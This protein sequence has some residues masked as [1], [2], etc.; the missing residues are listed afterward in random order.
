MKIMWHSVAPWVGTGYGMQ[1][2]L[3]TTRLAELGNDVR[4]SA[5]YG[6]QGSETMWRG[7]RVLPSYGAAYGV[8][9]IVPHAVK[10]FT[11]DR[12]DVN[13]LEVSGMGLVITLCDVWTQREAPL[14]DMLAIASWT[15]VDHLTVPTIVDGFF[16]QSGAI[17]IAMSRFGQEALANA[18]HRALYVP[19]GVDTRVFK[20]GDQDQARVATGTPADAFVVGMVANNIGRDGNRKAFAEQIT[21]FAELRRR[22][23]DAFLILHTDVDAPGGMRIRPF[24]ER[25]LPRDSY[26]FSDQYAYRKGL[27]AE[28]VASI[29]RSM[30]VLTNCSYGEG[31]GVPIIEAQACG[32]PVVVT[33]A[34]AMT[35]LSGPG[36]LVGYERMW[37]DSQGA[38][39]ATPRIGDIVDAYE[40]AYDKARDPLMR[41]EAWAFAQEYD[42]DRITA[43]HWAPALETLEAALE[44]RRTTVARRLAIPAHPRQ[45]EQVYRSA[46]GFM[47]I[48]RGNTTDDWVAHDDH[49]EWLDVIM[50]EQLPEGGVLLDVGAHV[51][52]W[53][54]RLSPKALHVVAVEA[55]PTTAR[56]LRRHLAMNDVHNVTVLEM[57]A[58]DEETDLRIEDPNG[59]LDGGGA[60]VYEADPDQPAEVLGRRLDHGL[61]MS[62]FAHY[63]RLDLV[64]MDVEGA[65]LHALRGMS[66]LLAEYRPAMIIECHDIYGYYERAD[67]EALLTELG[68]TF[69]VAASV[70][71]NWQPGVGIIDEVRSA[72]Y[73]LARP[74]QVAAGT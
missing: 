19:H 26:A 61:I 58:W 56:T 2:G 3:F 40:A 32:R 13:P 73:L 55:N 11:D 46:D 25:M 39:A 42:A 49:E 66:G 64:K 63:G 18:G 14:L 12:E 35:E 1:T 23:S 34:T 69:E 48:D 57:A 9:T 33:D 44:A 47:W 36:W 74:V 6:T 4:I 20:P 60:R 5:Y 21:A 31:F 65:D 41:E 67:L 50:D 7:L 10:F 15:P 28:A 62:M 29:Y 53:S 71:S 51:G 8:D 17:P 54:I 43:E 27:S 30:D 38:F 72:D 68:Y 52:R 45:R 24:L 16:T 70:G 22:H 59:R 37:H